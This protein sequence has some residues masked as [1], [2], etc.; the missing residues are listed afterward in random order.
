MINPEDYIRDHDLCGYWHKDI[1]VYDSNGNL[2]HSAKGF[3]VWPFFIKDLDLL[4]ASKSKKQ[5][6]Y[7]AWQAKKGKKW[8]KEWHRK[9]VR[10]ARRKR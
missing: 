3:M 7:V 6:R 9:D 10:K 1:K 2:Q 4:E 8:A 5:A